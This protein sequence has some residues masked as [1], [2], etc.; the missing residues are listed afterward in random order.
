MC[1]DYKDMFINLSMNK[2]IQNTNLKDKEEYFSIKIE[3]NINNSQ[4]NYYVKV[5]EENKKIFQKMNY[6][7]S[8]AFPLSHYLP[9]L[10]KN[11]SNIPLVAYK[12][13]NGFMYI[14][15]FTAVQLKN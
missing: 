2:S 7:C 13:P 15:T 10:F 9:E 14:D 5:D 1:K 11:D 6:Y 12:I 4:N 8:D 3:N